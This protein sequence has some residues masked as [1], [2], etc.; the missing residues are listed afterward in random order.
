REVHTWSK[1]SHENIVPM[2]GISTD[3]NSTISIISEWMPWGNAHMYVQNIENDPRPLVRDIANGLCYLHNHELGPVVHGDL[4]GLN[5]LVSSDH[6]A[7]LSDFGLSTLNLSSFS[8]TT[9]AIRGGSFPWMA[10]ELLNNGSVSIETDVWAFGMTVVELFTRAPPFHD[11]TS[12]ANVMYRLKCGRLPLRPAAQSTRSRLTSA[13]WA[14]CTSCWRTD[15]SSR[16]TMAV[17][18]EHV[19]RAMVCI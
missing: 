7:L 9:D 8:M 19:W 11:C 2:F 16:P 3:F 13:W 17:V 5:V 4:K 18:A 15:P 12:L 1:L 10:P 14:I 6:R